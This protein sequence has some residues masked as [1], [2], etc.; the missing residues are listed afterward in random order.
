LIALNRISGR[1]VVIVVIVVINGN[2]S[3]AKMHCGEQN[4]NHSD[5]RFG[6]FYRFGDEFRLNCQYGWVD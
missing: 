5:P 3:A 1:L 4:S 2:Q 6:I